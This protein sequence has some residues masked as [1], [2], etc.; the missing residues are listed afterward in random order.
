LNKKHG[1]YTN[2]FNDIL[3]SLFYD[4]LRNDRSHDDHYYS[5]FNCKIPFLNGGLFDP[6]GNY[7][8]VHIDITLPNE[9]FSNY[10]RTKQENTGD[11][12]FD[13]F[14]RYNFTVIEDEPLEKEVAIDPELLGKAYEKFN[15]IRPDNFTE[16]LKALKSGNKGE[17]NKFNKQYGV[18]YTPREI[19]HYM[20]R[21][22][23]INYLASEFSPQ[24]VSHEK[25]G[26]PQLDMLGNTGK[27]GQLDLITEHQSFPVISQKDF[28]TLINYGELLGENEAAVESRGKETDTYF[29]K[30]PAS[31][32]EN[33]ELIDQRLAEILICDPAVGSGAFPVGMMHEIVN[34][35]NILSIFIKHK[36]AEVGRSIYSFKRECIE[37]SLYGVDIDSGAV[38]IAKLRLWLSLVVDE[39]DINNIK[40]LPNLDYKIVCGNSLLGVVKNIFNNELFEHLEKLKP[41]HFNETNPTKK[42]E[43]K[44]QINELILKI[45]NGYKDFD[46]EVY[47]S[48]VFHHKDGFDIVIGNPPYGVK[49]SNKEKIFLR[50]NYPETQFKIDSYSIFILKSIQLL[51]SKGICFYIIPNTL[52]DNYFEEKVRTKLLIQNKIIEITDLNDN[53]FDSVVTHSM[54]FAFQ[55]ILQ[56]EYQIK[57]V[58]D[59]Q[60]F[61]ST[62]YIP[63]SFFLKQ[64]K[65]LFSFRNFNHNELLSKLSYS[66]IPL[67]QVLDLRQ[68]IKTGNDKK[69]IKAEKLKSNYKPILRGKDIFKWTIYNPNLFVGY[70]KHLA[71]PRDPRIFE[72]PKILIRETGN[73]IIATYDGDK[74][75][76]MSSLYNGILRDNRFCLKYLLALINS[77]IYQY[78]MNLLT[79]EKTKGAFTKARIFHYHKLPVKILDLDNQKLFVEKVDEI[80]KVKS[81]NPQANTKQLEDQID[82]MVYKLYNLTYEEVKIVDPNIEQ[83]ISKEEYERFLVQ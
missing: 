38:E 3:E 12:I 60:L 14:D 79:F 82:I 17:E 35:R 6:I 59:N 24:S 7:D 61:G 20:C 30:L 52:L 39:D 70:G 32:R 34:T 50:S 27:K 83:L 65:L 16:Y 44:N 49:Y 42:Q 33:A 18:Y 57:V 77:S 1:D 9:L 47:F 19:V 63:K 40:P 73:S 76:I 11:G 54:I 66:S 28:E 81:K 31:I 58:L 10:N 43:Y 71:C 55:R 8:W 51:K 53:V 13:I 29:Y 22:S 72:Q 78:Q 62:T 45:T 25:L 21:E 26:D 2:F 36:S 23:L 48:E 56:S 15:S 68:T 4:A 75:Y 74:F 80:L 5:H 67:E 46:F 64:D 69:Y 41:L 37:R